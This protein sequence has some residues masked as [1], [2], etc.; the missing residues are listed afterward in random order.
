MV[1]LKNKPEFRYVSRADGK[2]PGGY[3]FFA[4]LISM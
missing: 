1:A 2:T 4:V 3:S